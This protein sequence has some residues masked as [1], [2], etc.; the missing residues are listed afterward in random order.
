MLAGT[1]ASP[2]GDGP[3]P[4]A[5]V[6]HGGFWR[7]IWT[8]DLMDGIAVDL[9]RRGWATWNIEYRR[10]GQEGGGWPGTFRPDEVGLDPYRF[11]ATFGGKLAGGAR[12]YAGADVEQGRHQ[13]VEQQT[14]QEGGGQG[15]PAGG[16][17]RL[18]PRPQDERQQLVELAHRVVVEEAIDVLPKKLKSFYKDHR[19]IQR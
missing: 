14:G 7:E 10:V 11:L 15:E 9:T 6:I 17:E 2:E 1:F 13:Q 4:V 5:V 16:P 12:T 3:F 18:Q 19:K 8:R